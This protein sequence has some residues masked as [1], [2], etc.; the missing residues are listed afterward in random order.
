MTLKNIIHNPHEIT[1][2]FEEEVANYVGSLYAVAI[3]SCTNAL[4]LCCKYLQVDKV[5]IPRRTYLSVPQSIIHAG[6]T[7]IFSNEEWSGIYQLK[8]YPIYDAAKRLTSAMYISDQ[9][10]CLS[11]H[12]KKLLALGKGGMILTDSEKAAEWFRIARYE[13]RSAG[14]YKNIDIT[15][16]GWNFYMMPQVAAR[17]LELMQNYPEHVSDLPEEGGYRDLTEFTIFKNIEVID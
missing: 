8:P 12:V 14:N 17:G 16:L 9:F 2:M 6:G 5:T 10:M 7:V 1:K 3:D 13:G 4:F 11:F 15:M